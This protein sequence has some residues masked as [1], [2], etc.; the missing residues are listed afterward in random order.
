MFPVSEALQAPIG[1]PEDVVP[2]LQPATQ[3]AAGF[4]DRIYYSFGSPV[5]LKDLNPKDKE[6]CAETYKEIKNAVEGEISWLLEARVKDPFRD[7]LKRQAYERIADLDRRPREVKAGPSKGG[8][9]R[10]YGARAPSFPLDR[11]EH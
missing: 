5:D 2:R 9:I 8:M 11:A 1:F 7:F 6:A 4:G 10:N 3:A